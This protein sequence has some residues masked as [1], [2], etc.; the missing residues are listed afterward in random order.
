MWTKVEEVD[1]KLLIMIVHVS[2]QVLY[3]PNDPSEK[4]L[5]VPQ[6]QFVGQFQIVPASVPGIKC[7]Y[8]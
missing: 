1:I 8:S 2:V 3:R 4:L 5:I 7:Q 6:G